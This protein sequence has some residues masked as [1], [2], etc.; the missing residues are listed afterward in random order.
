MVEVTGDKQRERTTRQ[1]TN[2]KEQSHVYLLCILLHLPGEDVLVEKLLQL[3][4]GNIDAA[5]QGTQ[6][7]RDRER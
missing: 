4:V 7:D 2:N 3:L 6:T 5:L 1:Q